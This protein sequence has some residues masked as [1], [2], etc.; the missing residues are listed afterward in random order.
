MART[1]TQIAAEPFRTL[2]VVMRRVAT[3]VSLS[4]LFGV[5][6]SSLLADAAIADPTYQAMNAAGGI[7]WRSAP[8]WNTPVAQAGNG[9][10]NGTTIAVHCYRSGTTVPGSSNTMWE[11]ATVVG[12][13]GHGSG[14][15]NEHFINDGVG[16]NQHSPGV[17]PCSTP[18]N[19][20]H[21]S[22]GCYGD[23]CSGKDP[24]KTGCSSGAQTLASKDL[25]GARLEL[26]WS[27]R[28]KTE[29]AR[30][31]QYPLGLK[32]DLPTQLVARQDTGYTQSATYDVNGVPT[33]R[34]ASSKS[35]GITISWT[36]MIYSPVHLV[37]AVAY[38]Q[39]GG[40]SIKGSIV[41]CALNG[42]V[43]TEAR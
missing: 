29:W 42:K 37:R 28:C 2:R 25:S 1:G 40:P 13:P 26:R 23:Y 9:V 5:F 36:P 32:S 8:D 34:A 12:G 4:L 16:I 27:S 15:V 17:P 3:V 35:G 22:N 21:P 6:A 20:P 18:P 14:W 38:V 31:I 43:Q 10:Y 39:C 24:H 41:D 7:Y 30:W 11:Q 33:D 19:T